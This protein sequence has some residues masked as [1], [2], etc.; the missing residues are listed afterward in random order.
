MKRW[1]LR[2]ARDI[3]LTL[4]QRLVSHVRENGLISWIARLAWWRVTRS[5]MRW[6]HDL[7]VTG[8]ERIP[9]ETAFVM[10]ANHA[11]HLD[12]LALT[13][14]LSGR[15]ALRCYA[16][17]AGDTFFRGVPKSVFSALAINA[18]PVW[19]GKT[20]R[21]HLD[22][23]RMRLIEDRCAYILF[24][25]GT[26]ARDGQLAPFRAGMLGALAVG[27]GVPVLPCAI[28]GAYEAMPPG[29]RWPRVHPIRVVIGEPM[30]FEASADERADWSNASAAVEAAVRRLLEA[31]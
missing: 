25:E 5:Y 17:A 9:S 10:V 2:P 28:F 15:T 29:R 1:Q 30:R 26:R 27:T 6:R 3:G 22:T 24:P 21:Q 19:R 11:S 31:G 4:S 20:R 14:A 7:A 12:A 8:A 13:A 23:L 16:L 18:L